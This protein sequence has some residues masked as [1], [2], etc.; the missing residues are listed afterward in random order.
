MTTLAARLLPLR[1][2][3]RAR[4]GWLA[5]LAGVAV[6]M[7][8]GRDAP[9]GFDP[10]RAHVVL[11][12]GGAAL[13]AATGCASGDRRSGVLALWVQKPG[14]PGSRAMSRWT[15]AVIAAWAFHATATLAYVLTDPSVGSGPAARILAVGLLIDVLV[16]AVVF[17]FS[18][19]GIRLDVLPALVVVLYLGMVGEDAVRAPELFPT[20][21]P[22]LRAVR[23]PYRELGEIH[24]GLS[25]GPGA[26]LVDWGRIL[27]YGAAWIGVGLAGLHLGPRRRER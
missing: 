24:A 13:V 1:A 22:V 20:W 11:L 21:G 17:G 16:A 7:A 9:A 10:F 23:F 5:A 6:A 15:R 27:V 4:R 18:G 19:L 2:L 3:V 14:R 12:G 25:G 26:G 8:A